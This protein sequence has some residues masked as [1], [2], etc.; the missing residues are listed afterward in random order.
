VAFRTIIKAWLLPIL[1]GDSHGTIRSGARK[2][3]RAAGNSLLE[4][5]GVHR[6]ENCFWQELSEMMVLHFLSTFRALHLRRAHLQARLGMQS[7]ALF[8]I[9]AMPAS[10]AHRQC[11]NNILIAY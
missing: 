1:H 9:P 8:A 11:G 2:Q 5:A 7:D 3:V 6:I 10:E 4:A